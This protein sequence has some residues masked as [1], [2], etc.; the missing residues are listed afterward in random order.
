MR[1]NP[2]SGF[3]GQHLTS[4]DKFLNFLKFKNNSYCQLQGVIFGL[5]LVSRTIFQE[6]SIH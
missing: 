3:S 1:L 6:M 4:V 5:I 2:K